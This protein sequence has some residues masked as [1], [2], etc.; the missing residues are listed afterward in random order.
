MKNTL[1][2]IG[3]LSLIVLFVGSQNFVAAQNNEKNVPVLNGVWRTVV[4]PR[5]CN[6]GVPVGITFPGILLFERD[7]TM[8]GTST[9]VTSAY[10]TWNRRP[11]RGEY[12]FASLSFKYDTNGNMVGS[13]I[14]EQ[15]VTLDEGGDSFSSTGTFRD[16]DPAGNPTASGCSTATGSR[17]Q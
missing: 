9:A 3:L 2:S 4:T 13:R 8:T 15:N 1:R 14:I 12:S 6:T 11:G 7:G 16:Y 10:G 5:I 17:F